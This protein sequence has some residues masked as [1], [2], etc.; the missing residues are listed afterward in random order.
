MREEKRNNKRFEK[1]KM[2][3]ELM[4]IEIHLALLIFKMHTRTQ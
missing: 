1:K 4:F 2:I 3:Y